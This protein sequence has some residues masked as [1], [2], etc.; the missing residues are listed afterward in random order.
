MN[1]LF[2]I[3]VS[4]ALIGASGLFLYTY[5]AKSQKSTLLIQAISDSASLNAIRETVTSSINNIIKEELGL[6]KNFDFEFF[7]PKQLNRLTLYYVH[8][9]HEN[10]EKDLFSALTF[11]NTLEA[12]RAVAI[13]QNIY[14]FGDKQDELVVIIDDPLQEL[15]S[16]N[17]EIK[18]RLH[19]LDSYNIAKS[20]Q[21]PYLP[22]IGLGRIRFGSIKEHIKDTD[23]VNEIFDRI[24]ERIIKL[25][26]EV[27][28]KTVTGENDKLSFTKIG[29][30]DLQKKAYV[31]EYEFKSGYSNVQQVEQGLRHQVVISGDK[32]QH[33]KLADRMKFYKAPAVSIAMI[34]HGKVSWAKGYG[35]VSF[36]AHAQ[37]VDTKT[38][39]Q[40]ASI[41]KPLTAMGALLLVQQ[42]KISLDEDVN[43]YLTSWKIP[44]NEFTKTE[45][46]T[47]R[48]LLSHTAGTSVHGFPGYAVGAYIPTV[49]EIL[50]GKK[51]QVHTDPVRVTQVPG[52]EFRYSG[53]GT[54]IVQLLI[55]DVTG[56]KF[57]VWMKKNILI[58]FGMSSSTFDQPLTQCDS[59]HAAHGYQ[60]DKPVAGRWHVYPEKAPAGLWTTPTDLAQFV[61]TLFNILHDKQQ[62]PLDKK[63]VQEALKIQ[64]KMGDNNGAGLGFVLQGSGKNIAFWHGG[65]NEGFISNLVAYPELGKGWIIMVNNQAANE[66]MREIEYSIADVYGIP[67]K[68]P[69]IKNMVKFDADLAKKCAGVYKDKDHTLTILMHGNN[70]FL[71]DPWASPREMQL[72][73]MGNN[74]FFTKELSSSLQFLG[75][76]DNID[77]A[78]FILKDGKKMTDEDNNVIEF[79]KTYEAHVA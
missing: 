44:E 69:I 6:D 14:F 42:G 19:Q 33:M 13:T 57:D 3:F 8:D 64:F 66:L 5:T 25:T 51:P 18:T 41:S 65:L 11:L 20:E 78:V 1:R 76:N 34:D 39:F 29:I 37:K 38:L 48:R 56:E 16:L 26:Q 63:L 21:H 24:R 62:G 7:I 46:V 58:P 75:S 79:K 68:E 54:T 67:G 12:L 74:T 52:K 77:N 49:V 9:M 70:L 45:K 10:G 50:E 73:Y 40:A 2:L 4:A 23:Q 59:E 55:E 35:T 28:S 53:G 43:T 22:H 30:L 71:V 72:Y 61:V 60:D 36:D 32:K 15:A 31:K 47:L 17:T 27:I